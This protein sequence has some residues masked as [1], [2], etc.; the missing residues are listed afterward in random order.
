ML[1]AMYYATR[2]SH[3]T[4]GQSVHSSVLVADDC[5]VECLKEPTGRRV[6]EEPG[7]GHGDHAVRAS[8][9]RM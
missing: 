4:S 8:C 7:S 3:F 5:I 1:F 6:L 9:S 2:I